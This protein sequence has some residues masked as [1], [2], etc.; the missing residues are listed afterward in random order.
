MSREGE[1][2]FAEVCA[3]ALAKM[4]RT[5]DLK[6]VSNAHVIDIVV[7]KDGK[8]YRYQGDWLKPLAKLTRQTADKLG[9]LLS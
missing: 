1:P 4:S 3:E 9:R 7:R 8:E 6:V 5:C 2:R